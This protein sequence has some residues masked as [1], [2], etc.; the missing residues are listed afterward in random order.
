MSFNL[1]L[2]DGKMHKVSLYAV[3]YDKHGRSEQV[4]VIDAATGTVLDTETLSSFTGGEYLSWNLSG[5]VVIKV[6]NLNPKA[7]AVVS[8]LFFD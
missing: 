4:Q 7:N 3:D 2:T 6:T 8:G 5:N 1:D